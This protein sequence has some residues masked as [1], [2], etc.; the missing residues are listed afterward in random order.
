M[1]H[2][3]FA[4]I[5]LTPLRLSGS[6]ND[7]ITDQN[8]YQSFNRCASIT[9]GKE[10]GYSYRLEYEK[11]NWGK[12]MLNSELSIGIGC[13]IFDFGIGYG[14]FITNSKWFA[15]SVNCHWSYIQLSGIKFLEHKGPTGLFELEFR[16]TWARF[17]INVAPFYRYLYLDDGNYIKNSYGLRIGVVRSFYF[18][19]KIF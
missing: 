1:I 10:T 18:K 13:L 3:V 6:D 7:S 11:G 12:A 5:L 9:A 8:N 16:K 4:V 17:S 15:T 2:L 19:K 14:Y